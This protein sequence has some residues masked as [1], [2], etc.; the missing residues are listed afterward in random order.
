MLII[1]DR[2]G[3]ALIEEKACPIPIEMALDMSNGDF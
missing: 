1:R 3:V 2:L